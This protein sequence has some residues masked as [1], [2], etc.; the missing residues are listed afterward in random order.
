[1]WNSEYLNLREL[2]WYLSL[3]DLFENIYVCI[4]VVISIFANYKRSFKG[5]I[6]TFSKEKAFVQHEHCEWNLYT[7]RNCLSNFPGR[8]CWFQIS[9][10]AL[11][12][13]KHKLDLCIGLGN[14]GVK[15]ALAGFP[16]PVAEMVSF[17]PEASNG[18]S[19]HERLWTYGDQSVHILKN[20]SWDW[21]QISRLEKEL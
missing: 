13:L 2:I 6:V 19:T 12:H 15:G 20:G 17:I 3:F 1:M 18:Q 16:S 7:F 21:V 5:T 4:Y 9:C 14:Q 8:L 11:R 10:W